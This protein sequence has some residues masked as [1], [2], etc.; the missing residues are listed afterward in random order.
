MTGTASCLQFGHSPIESVI[1]PPPLASWFRS[2]IVDR[3]TV[4]AEREALYTDR[5]P[6]DSR[7]S[8]PP[9][10]GAHELRAAAEHAYRE[11]ALDAARRD[12]E[13]AIGEFQETR[14][15]RGLAHTLTVL[16]KTARAAGEMALAADTYRAALSAFNVLGDLP[17]TIRLYPALAEVLF[18]TGDYAGAAVILR[19]ALALVPGDAA[20]LI[21]LGHTEWL[22][23]HVADAL[24][25][26]T[27]AL[28]DVG[29]EARN[30]P[31]ALSVRGQIRADIGRAEAAI[32]D[33]DRALGTGLDAP[34]E[35][36][37]RSARALALSLLGQDTD[38][39]SELAT[40][41]SLA[42]ERARTH[43]RAARMVRHRH[44]TPGARDDLRRALSA[45]PALPPAHAEEARRLLNR[46]TA[47]ATATA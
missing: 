31:I 42:P 2:T 32:T 18:S 21:G 26:L 39:D 41:R 19:E 9:A 4:L 38:A 29:S 23:G 7:R 47:T 43:L 28:S 44:D 45:D 40:A 35:A 12:S 37:T 10:S 16:G 20:C 5:D 33:L 36:D 14:D 17:S 13:A 34:D 24:T 25:L 3:E 27:E 22:A 46:L 11:G 1:P 15:E 8:G 30:N 6:L